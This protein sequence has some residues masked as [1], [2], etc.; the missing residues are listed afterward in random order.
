MDGG[1]LGMWSAGCMGL[2]IQRR[3]PVLNT[4]CSGHNTMTTSNTM[5]VTK[6]NI[7]F[8]SASR[9]SQPKVRGV[10]AGAIGALVAPM[11]MQT[12]RAVGLSGASDPFMVL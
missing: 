6:I 11:S 5:S 8:Q 1:G 10:R 3:F 2:L 7:L 4:H 9:S 12:Q